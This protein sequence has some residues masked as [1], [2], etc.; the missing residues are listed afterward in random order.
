MIQINNEEN[1]H[2]D[3]IECQESEL[4]LCNIKTKLFHIFEHQLP[5]SK[6]V[7]G[8]NKNCIR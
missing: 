3:I 1:D 7:G 6:N 2:H 4:Y 5:C 8:E